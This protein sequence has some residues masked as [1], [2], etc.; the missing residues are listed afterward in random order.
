M[1]KNWKP[2]RLP[3]EVFEQVET[4]QNELQ[5]RSIGKV[6][7]YQAIQIAVSTSSLIPIPEVKR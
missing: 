2:A 1:A 6:T 5:K 7:F 4:L 3:E